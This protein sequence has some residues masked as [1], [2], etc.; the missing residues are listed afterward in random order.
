MGE[1][2]MVKGECVLFDIFP[3]VMDIHCALHLRFCHIPT[4]TKAAR[5]VAYKAGIEELNPQ[6]SCCKTT[7]IV[8]RSLSPHWSLHLVRRSR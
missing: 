3:V 2:H 7:R 5:G 8:T 1:L 6:M 4:D